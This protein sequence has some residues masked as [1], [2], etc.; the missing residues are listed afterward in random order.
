MLTEFL[1]TLL[2]HHLDSGA[3]APAPLPSA[4]HAAAHVTAELCV[5][6]RRTDVLFGPAFERFQAAGALG[7][8]V[9][10][11]EPLI[12]RGLLPAPNPEIVQAFV[13]HYAAAGAPDVVQRAVL[14]MDIPSLDFNQVARLCRTHRLYAALIHIF[15][16]GLGDFLTPACELLIEVAH[17]LYRD[18]VADRQ[19]PRGAHSLPHGQVA[20]VPFLAQ[21][22]VET[23]GG[24]SDDGLSDVDAQG[25]EE[26]PAAAPV[27]EEAV[28]VD[29]RAEYG[30]RLLAYVQCCLRGEWF[31]PGD[32]CAVVDRCALD[33][34]SA[35]AHCL[36][37]PI[38][39]H[40]RTRCHAHAAAACC[41]QCDGGVAAGG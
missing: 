15:N 36:H 41:A 14:H 21:D 13:E 18:R 26:V 16:R 6:L 20:D 2:L 40:V 34:C 22:P 35:Y 39:N 19:L 33:V 30:Y 27:L 38:T 17:G 11:L 31:P 32:Q 3:L 7:P 25:P 5:L 4:W 12:V 1:L 28:P 10:A 24:L 37:R 23:C 9:T 8:F 29:W